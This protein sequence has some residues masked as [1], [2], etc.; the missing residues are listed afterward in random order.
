MQKI[1][2]PKN[3]LFFMRLQDKPNFLKGIFL[4][5]LLSLMM[6]VVSATFLQ[7][8]FGDLGVGSVFSD[9][10][11]E[12]CY[13]K[14]LS[15]FGRGGENAHLSYCRDHI[16]CS[17]FGGDLCNEP[18]E[19]CD[20]IYYNSKETPQ[21]QGIENTRC[22][23]AG[24]CVSTE[25]VA[26]EVCAWNE[27]CWQ[28][29]RDKN[30]CTGE[31]QV[32]YGYKEKGDFCNADNQ[33][34]SG[35]CDLFACSDGGDSDCFIETDYCS[36]DSECCGDLICSSNRCKKDLRD[37][38]GNLNAYCK[39]DS[40]CSSD[41]KGFDLECVNNVC[42]ITDDIPNL[43]TKDCGGFG[44]PECVMSWGDNWDIDD[45][46]DNVNCGTANSD[47]CG[48]FSWLSQ[49]GS[50]IECYA[51]ITWFNFWCGWKWVVIVALIFLVLLIFAP[52]ILIL[53]RRVF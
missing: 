7:D 3:S 19:T 50:R 31:C 6:P 33:C 48:G 13:G 14:E 11:Y 22:C 26:W 16:K 53:L 20:G 35:S 46:L 43:D 28:G 39:Y 9:P 12:G 21:S 15:S 2:K 37:L 5:C 23:V 34:L 1:Y 47:A 40:D 36:S 42:D 32:L 18:S 41:W 27:V 52:W 45:Y 4:L 51:K 44:Q 24:S 25:E 49:A 30:H 29:N 38:S 17:N 8:F 10:T